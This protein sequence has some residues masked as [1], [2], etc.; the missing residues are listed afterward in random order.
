MTPKDAA[1]LIESLPPVDL[2]NRLFELLMWQAKTGRS[3]VHIGWY[4]RC[5]TKPQLSPEDRARMRTLCTGLTKPLPAG[6][7]TR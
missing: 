1:D 6:M 3:L 2:K 5:L 4:L 7:R